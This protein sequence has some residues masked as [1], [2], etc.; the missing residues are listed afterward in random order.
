MAEQ[1]P[2]ERT[3]RREIVIGPHSAAFVPPDTYIIRTVGVVATDE[4]VRLCDAID[5]LVVGKPVLYALN[6][7]AAAGR[8]SAE[9]RK[10]LLTRMPKATAGIVFVNVSTFDRIGIS[11]GAKAY[12]MMTRGREIPY[13]FAS[14]V[15]EAHAWIAEQRLHASE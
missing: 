5:E 2:S 10:L 1:P 3:E 7:L 13:A 15:E 8:L 14:T 11:L 6:D 9:G 12:V 4:V